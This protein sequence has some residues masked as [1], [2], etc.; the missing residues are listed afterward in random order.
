MLTLAAVKASLVFIYIMVVKNIF[1]VS[2][3]V[4]GRCPEIY[5]LE[6]NAKPAARDIS[7][8]FIDAGR[9]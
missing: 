6:T 1:F 3:A 9:A 2:K 4:I 5:S 8:F 7:R